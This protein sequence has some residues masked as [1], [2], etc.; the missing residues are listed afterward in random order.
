MP[1]RAGHA[2]I[3]PDPEWPPSVGTDSSVDRLADDD[4]GAASKGARWQVRW[5]R[6]LWACDARRTPIREW[7]D[8]A[9][10]EPCGRRYARQ[11]IAR[12]AAFGGPGPIADLRGFCRWRLRA[13][14]VDTAAP[15]LATS[16]MLRSL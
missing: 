13:G 14:D 2:P 5:M 3:R 1:K 6:I 16:D 9:R 12:A 11:E 8:C 4:S 7:R 15:R 10:R